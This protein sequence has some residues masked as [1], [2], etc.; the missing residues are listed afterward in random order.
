MEKLSNF[1]YPNNIKH[2]LKLMWLALMI[3]L[4]S[5]EITPS[6]QSPKLKQTE[7]TPSNDAPF[8][9]INQTIYSTYE[10][11]A[12][13]IHYLG[14]IQTLHLNDY[15]EELKKDTT[16]NLK[17]ETRDLIT[18]LDSTE[19]SPK[20][21][22]V[23]RQIIYETLFN[24]IKQ[25]K[26]FPQNQW[27]LTS[28]AHIVTSQ[29]H[30]EFDLNEEQISKYM[31]IQRIDP[32]VWQS[33]NQKTIDV[34]FEQIK[35]E[36]Q[37]IKQRNEIRRKAKIKQ[38]KAETI[39]KLDDIDSLN[40]DT[41]YSNGI[42]KYSRNHAA[43]NLAQHNI[44]LRSTNK[45][46][47]EIGNNQSTGRTSLVWINA[48]TVDYIIRIKQSIDQ[49]YGDTGIWYFTWWTEWW[50]HTPWKM[51]HPNW[52]KWDIRWKWIQALL[53]AIEYGSNKIWN[54]RNIYDL[55]SWVHA[56]FTYHD[57]CYHMDIKVVSLWNTEQK[58]AIISTN[59]K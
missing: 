58:N 24:Y 26:E 40:T 11:L 8:E 46:Y 14:F 45:W 59:G 9:V 2:A 49:K 44:K 27:E 31:Q 18:H 37:A 28:V 56:S 25:E 47:N 42:I 10:A 43:D 41:Y 17:P 6:P 15:I 52:F 20:H 29:L 19:Y 13:D 30:Q 16:L 57:P 33:L 34:I 39:K 53:L 32:G 1:S 4:Q 7:V 23:V 50:D 22:E 21:N 36:E 54:T 12:N 38:G 48:S 5:S 35:H 51:S 3:N 55:E